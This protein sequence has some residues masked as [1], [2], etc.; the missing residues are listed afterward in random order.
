KFLKKRIFEPLKMTRTISLYSEI[1]GSNNV[2]V[3]HTLVND[4]VETTP[5]PD[6]DDLAPAGSILSSVSD[7]S[8]WLICQLD[9]GRFE[10][11]QVI[12]FSAIKKTRQ[13]QSIMG[14]PWTL[15]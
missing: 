15:F 2:A 4:T 3:G 7:L 8:H 5:Y 9:S 1:F 6:I 11:N 12:P 14:R 13:P 10:G